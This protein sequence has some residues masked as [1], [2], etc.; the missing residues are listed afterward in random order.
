MLVDST[1]ELIK[2]KAGYRYIGSQSIYIEELKQTGVIPAINGD[3]EHYFTLSKFDNSTEAISKLQLNGVMTDAFWRAGFEIDKIRSPV[4][5]P[6][7][8]WGEAKNI[9][10]VT[11]S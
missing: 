4:S 9:E 7:A 11:R 8:N 6:Y 5:F 1:P 10:V 3:G 2:G